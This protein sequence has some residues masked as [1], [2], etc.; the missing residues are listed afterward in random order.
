M[1]TFYSD[2]KDYFKSLGKIII[3]GGIIVGTILAI[4]FGGV[5]IEGYY[6]SHFERNWGLTI[7]IFIMVTGSGV[8]SGMT[9]IAI[10]EALTALER[11]CNNIVYL[12][13]NN[14]RTDSDRNQNDQDNDSYDLRSIAGQGDEAS[15]GEWICPACG[16]KNRSFDEVCSCGEDKNKQVKGSKFKNSKYLD[17]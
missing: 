12:G 9:M 13:T 7:G 4:A 2:A 15:S 16:K 5:T 8:F 3:I 17:I 10:S 14:D 1:I 11:I 6:S